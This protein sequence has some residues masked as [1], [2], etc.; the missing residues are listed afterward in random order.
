MA[1]LLSMPANTLR[2]SRLIA[3]LAV[4]AIVSV[5]ANKANSP[6]IGWVSFALFLCAVPSCTYQSGAAPPAKSVVLEFSTRRRRKP[7]RL[8][9]DR[10]S[11]FSRRLTLRSTEPGSTD[12][13]RKRYGAATKSSCCPSHRLWETRAK[14]STRRGHHCPQDVAGPAR[15]CRFDSL[16]ARR[17]GEKPALE[18]RRIVL[19]RAG[20]S[21]P[22][23]P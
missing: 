7:I 2:L 17:P 20:P 15:H 3:V 10:M 22:V 9:P 4:A 8:R 14:P 1:I 19:R 16:R 12:S 5:V 23:R 11:S 18:H 21:A 6:S 13:W